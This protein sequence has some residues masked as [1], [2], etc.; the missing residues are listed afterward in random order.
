M[1]ANKT[2]EL[3]KS[4]IDAETES[5]KKNWGEN[6]HSEHEAYAVL[7]EE[8]E[9]TNEAFV[10]IASIQ[11]VLWNFVRKAKKD[12]KDIKYL[13]DNLHYLQDHAQELATEAVQIAAVAQKYIDTIGDAK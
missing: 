13:K 3:I 10:K 4:A 8:I 7:T 12:D 11:R 6:Y 1:E 2:K 9:E 5:A